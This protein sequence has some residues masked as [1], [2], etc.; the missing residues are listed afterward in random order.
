MADFNIIK[1][2]TFSMPLQWEDDKVSWKPITGITK[3]APCVI[4]CPAHGVPEGWRVAVVSVKGMTQINAEN[5]PPKDKDY[6][7]ATVLTADTIE[8]NKVNALDFSAYTSGGSLRY[9]P[10]V[11][12]TGYAARM[13]IKD[14]IGGTLLMSLTTENGGITIDNTA[15]TITLNISA[16]DTAAI[17]WKKGVFDL[18]MVSSGGVVTK[19]VEATPITV[20][21][22]VTT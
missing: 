6:H 4:T 11:D 20:S 10:P 18:E 21:G 3:A 22:E 19:I 16:A 1:G 7:V 14:K 8:L 5:D 17:A 9:F 15:K 2:S 12:L 13:T